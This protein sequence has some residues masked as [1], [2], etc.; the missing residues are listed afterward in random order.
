MVLIRSV[1]FLFPTPY[2][3]FPVFLEFPV[4]ARP[5]LSLAL[6]V[7]RVLAD[8]PHYTLARNHLAL[9]ANLLY[10]CPD[11]HLLLPFSAFNL[12][13]G[14]KKSGSGSVRNLYILTLR[15]GPFLN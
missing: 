14:Y 3:L 7:L 15:R 11:L 12:P 4:P 8:D 1:G 5:C 13:R 10:R 6:L 9:H 2:C